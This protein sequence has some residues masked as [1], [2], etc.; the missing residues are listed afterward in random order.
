MLPVPIIYF[1]FVNTRRIHESRGELQFLV[2]TSVLPSYRKKASESRS[3]GEGG[4]SSFVGYH[5]S[6]RPSFSCGDKK[7]ATER[8]SHENLRHQLH[9]FLARVISTRLGKKSAGDR[10]IISR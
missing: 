9:L 4:R 7:G 5:L 1:S 2:L 8:G 3:V 6:T 10:E